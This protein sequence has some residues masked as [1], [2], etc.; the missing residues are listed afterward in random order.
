MITIFHGENINP[1]RLKMRA[2][3][4]DYQH[5]G[6]ALR[7][8]PS[9]KT[10]TPELLIEFVSATDLFAP[11]PVFLIEELHSL[12]IGK[13]RTALIDALVIATQPG[14]TL[15]SPLIPE[16]IL[17]EKKKLTS[18]MIKKF[19]SAAHAELF[20]PSKQIWQFL[21]ALSARPQNQTA[22]LRQYHSLLITDQL[23]PF[24]LLA[25]L[26]RQIRLLI[27][28][29]SGVTPALAPFQL[30]PLRSQAAHF[31]LDQLLTAHHRLLE[32]EVGQKT[33]V[34]PFSLDKD[35]WLWVMSLSA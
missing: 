21:A 13:K 3:V 12:P 2:L 16:L 1:S 27:Q 7:S 28:V 29:K 11:P 25:L 8:L 26:T 14:A 4:Q 20:E 6:F 17:W 33:G 22:L 18:L 23:D 10:L 15:T 19:G 9:P 35:L 5:R 24:H 32:I 31:T 30:S 34:S